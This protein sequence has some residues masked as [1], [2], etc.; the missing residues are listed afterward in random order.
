MQHG[1][2]SGMLIKR[3][4]SALPPQYWSSRQFSRPL[5]TK[6]HSYS[7]ASRNVAYIN[8]GHREASVP[9][10][11]IGDDGKP[12]GYHID[13]C[14]VFID[15]IKEVLEEAGSQAVKHVPITSQTR[16]ALIAN[17]TI[18]MACGSATNNLTRQKQVDYL[19][20]TFIAGTKLGHKKGSG[21]KEIEDLNGKV[22]CPAGRHHQREG[23][24]A[25]HQ[26]KEPRYPHRARQRTILRVGSQSTPD[27]CRRLWQRRRP[28]L[29]PDQQ[30]ERPECLP[31]NRAIPLL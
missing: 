11:Y 12:Q 21:I 23:R 7:S 2:D 19:P 10:A 20:V 27:A 28:D 3:H 6:D 13:I 29:R 30:V 1:E 17:G 22:D 16:L 14:N 24:Q 25:R 4:L 5:R 31:G 18:D 9:F 8:M 15:K 26:G